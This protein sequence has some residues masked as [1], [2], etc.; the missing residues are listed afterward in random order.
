MNFDSQILETRKLWSTQS[1]PPSVIFA[2]HLG[3]YYI[4]VEDYRAILRVI[5]TDGK[6]TVYVVNKAKVSVSNVGYIAK[7]LDMEMT[8]YLPVYIVPNNA[9]SRISCASGA[10]TTSDKFAKDAIRKIWYPHVA[11]S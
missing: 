4:V 6:G 8:K 1:N 7:E 9:L 3:V 11:T 2:S 10:I 5:G